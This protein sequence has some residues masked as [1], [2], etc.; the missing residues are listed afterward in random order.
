MNITTA[1][2]VV[3]TKTHTAAFSADE[4]KAAALS[5]AKKGVGLSDDK[6]ASSKVDVAADGEV[7]V[8]L[9]EVASEDA[10]T[11][12]PAPEAHLDSAPVT[13]AAPHLAFGR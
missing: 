12:A 3:T 8:E 1:T 10:A 6:I 11:P 9:V 2:K 5:L 4:V 7:T 13:P